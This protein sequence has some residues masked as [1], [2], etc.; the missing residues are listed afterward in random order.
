MSKPYHTATK[1]EYLG[2][3]PSLCIF[4][5]DNIDA[6]DAQPGLGLTTLTN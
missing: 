2:M 6:F 1:S 5:K 4:K 3:E